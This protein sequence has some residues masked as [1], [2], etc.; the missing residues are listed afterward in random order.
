MAWPLTPYRTMVDGSTYWDA[1]LGNALQS[2]INGLYTATAS[3]AG[4]V[5][6]GI[7]G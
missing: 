6:D 5:L 4:E 3:I 1:A 7:G 2:G